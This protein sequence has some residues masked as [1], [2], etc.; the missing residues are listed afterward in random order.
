MSE[1]FSGTKDNEY[2]SSLEWEWVSIIKV[3]FNSIQ[4]R[5]FTLFFLLQK[6]L[7]NFLL[8]QSAK[9]IVKL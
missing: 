1:V 8:I 6:K 2:Y 3:K 9:K 7:K 4:T 5:R